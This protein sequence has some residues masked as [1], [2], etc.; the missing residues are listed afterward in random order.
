MQTKFASARK[1]LDGHFCESRRNAGPPGLGGHARP[2]ASHGGR[3]AVLA[4]NRAGAQGLAAGARGGEGSPAQPLPR[5]GELPEA[6]YE[7][8][9]TNILPYPM[10]NVHPRFWSWVMGNGTTLGMLAEMLA[11]GFNP[12]MGGGEHVGIYVEQ[13]VLDWTKQMLGFPP[14]ASGLLVSGGSMA[15]LVALA[16]RAMCRPASMCAAR[17]CKAAGSG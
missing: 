15:N 16:V 10:G 8:F 17:G 14:E 1:G 6:I 5:E 4:G 13:Q 3:H 9:R 7:D 11:A 2:G 12:N